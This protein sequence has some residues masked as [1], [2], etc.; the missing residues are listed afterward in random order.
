MCALR[1]IVDYQEFEK[2]ILEIVYEDGID[3]ILASELAFAFDLD[4]CAATQHL[5]SA[6]TMGILDVD[7]NDGVSTYYVPGMQVGDEAV[8]HDLIVDHHNQSGADGALDGN[9]LS[10]LANADAGQDGSVRSSRLVLSFNESISPPM[11]GPEKTSQPNAPSWRPAPSRDLIPH[12]GTQLPSTIDDSSEDLMFSNASRSMFS[13]KI[14]IKDNNI[15]EEEL[16]TRVTNL[17]RSFGYAYVENRGN[18]IRFERGSVT[19][20]IALI[21]LF[22]L[23]LPMFVYLLLSVMGRST[24]QKE[25]ILLDVKMERKHDLESYWEIDLNFLGLHGVVLGPADQKVLNQ[26]IDTLKTE[27]LYA[28]PSQRH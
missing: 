10:N 6:V 17:F 2:K 24:I 15:D 3:R 13:R 14:R 28:F 20:L 11:G 18:T 26:E 9:A 1:L 4:E 19:F 16:V 8:N 22:V 21:P 5:E 7:F 23:I 12:Q 27:L 25:P